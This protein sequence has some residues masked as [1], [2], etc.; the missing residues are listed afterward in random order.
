MAELASLP[1]PVVALDR[2][3]TH[4]GV[5]GEVYRKCDDRTAEAY[6][7]N[8]VR[9]LEVLCGEALRLGASHLYATGA[10]GS[11][12]AAAACV[13]A[14]RVGLAPGVVLYP[15][16]HSQAAAANLGIVLEAC[17]RERVRD[18]RHWSALPWGMFTERRRALGRGEAPY[19]MVPG[20][21]TALG[22][23]GYVSGG[24]E[25]A[26]QVE[27]RELPPPRRVVVATGS[28]CTTAGLLVGL[29]LAARLGIGFRGSAGA[30]PPRLV[31]VRVTP[32]PVTSVWRILELAHRASRLLA[33]L[34]S[35]ERLVVERRELR[36]QLELD[37]SE[38]GGGYGMATASG[39]EAVALFDEH[40]G[41]ELETT[42]SGKS[43]AALVKPLRGDAGG[44]ILYW[45]TRTAPPERRAIALEA[46]APRM[47]R[48]L[49][50]ATCEGQ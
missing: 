32:W 19:F 16:P 27:A 2:L 6:G 49:R 30:A 38:L 15:Q 29:V 34:A 10:Y 41:L 47:R 33:E 18:L 37:G 42:Y 17:P 13:H 43:A 48:W 39:R 23:L 24:L 50:D 45:S 8:K 28:N 9:T 46:A 11:N 7:G 35:D 14:P 5:A 31:G 1:T 20:G 3:A 4:F 21:A 36:A 44:P 40:A 25:L 12:H 26:L 22:A